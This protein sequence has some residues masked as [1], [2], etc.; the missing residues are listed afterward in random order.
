MAIPVGSNV[1]ILPFVNAGCV[2][3]QG[4]VM[5]CCSRW[6]CLDDATGT[7]VATADYLVRYMTRN[8][9]ECAFHETRFCEA[10]LVVVPLV[11]PLSQR[12]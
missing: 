9:N 5:D 4:V 12:K 10:E 2:N 11:M 8:C 3:T 7:R 1:D 6:S